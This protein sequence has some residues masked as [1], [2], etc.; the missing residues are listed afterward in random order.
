MVKNNIEVDV[1]V[2]CIEEGDDTGTACG[3]SGDYEPVCKPDCEKT[4]RSCK[5]DVCGNDGAT[6]V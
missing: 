5:Q 1:K 6:G 3:K 4:G 2:K